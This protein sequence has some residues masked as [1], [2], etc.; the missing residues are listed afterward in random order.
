MDKHCLICVHITNRI[1]KAGEVQKIFTEYGANIKTRLGL[2]EVTPEYNS[3]AGI[4]VLEMV[5]EEKNCNEMMK[6]IEVL[7]GV[8][9]KKVVFEHY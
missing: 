6:K 7:E 5:G 8:E 2:H 9:V 3:P 4:I 1:K